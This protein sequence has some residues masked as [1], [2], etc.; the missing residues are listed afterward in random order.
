MQLKLLSKER[1]QQQ[2]K[3]SNFWVFMN[4]MQ[5]S[6]FTENTTFRIVQV[7]Y[8]SL[9]LRVRYIIISHWTWS[10]HDFPILVM[11]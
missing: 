11:I 9:D 7:G 2:Q 4:M 10:K 6:Q 5:H 8:T 3:K 1:N